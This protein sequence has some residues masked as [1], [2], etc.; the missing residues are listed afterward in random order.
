MIP[1]LLIIILALVAGMGGMLAARERERGRVA[2]AID[3]ARHRGVLHG[4]NLGWIH[5]GRAM[6]EIRRIPVHGFAGEC[7]ECHT[8]FGI[9]A[10]TSDE[11]WNC[12][13]CGHRNPAP[14]VAKD[15]CKLIVST[16]RKQ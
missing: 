3:R 13:S 7:A 15:P 1:L 4:M 9:I 5:H 11:Y 16:I 12:R 14:L 10:E 2:A 8:V 6:A